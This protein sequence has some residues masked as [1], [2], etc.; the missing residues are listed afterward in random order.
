V[1]EEFPDTTRRVSR[2]TLE[3]VH[4]ITVWIVTVELRRWDQGA[5]AKFMGLLHG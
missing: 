3:H 4:G 1:R 2:Q 5:V